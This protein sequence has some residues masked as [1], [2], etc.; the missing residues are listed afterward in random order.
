MDQPKLERLLRLMKLLTAN[1][2]YD[3]DQLAERLQMSRRTVYRY[4]D[5]FREAGFVIKKSGNCIR[6][7]KESPHFRDI[8]QLVHFTEEEAVILK[9]AIENIDDTNMLK[10]NLKRKL[11]SVY[12]NKTLADTV[13]RGKNSPNIRTLIEAIDEHRQVILHGYQSAHGG[14]VRDRR[15]EPFAF[16]TNYVQ[17][18]CY[19]PEAHACKLF[20]TSRIGS[21]ELTEAPWEHE[22]EHREGFIDAFRM[23]GGMRRRVRLEL[24][25]LAYNL[26]CEEYPLAERDVRPLGRGRWLLDTEVAGFAGVGRFVVGLLDDIRIVDSPELTTYI[27]NYIRANIS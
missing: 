3:I 15:V 9:S 26:L 17:V 19:D 21:A 6:L 7:D 10:Q 18:W 22:P 4:I 24:G 2:T 16:T 14:E 1:T 12:D 8:S 11:Y 13:L 27:H 25:L 5:T 23:H 20:K